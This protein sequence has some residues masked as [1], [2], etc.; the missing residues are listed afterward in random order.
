MTRNTRQIK[1]DKFTV[2][3]FEQAG[4][5]VYLNVLALGIKTFSKPLPASVVFE[6]GCAAQSIAVDATPKV[7]L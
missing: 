7:T 3:E 5:Q 6:L 1:I 4:N 2:I